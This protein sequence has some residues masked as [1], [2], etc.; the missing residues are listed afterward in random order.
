MI[1]PAT[2]KIHNLGGRLLDLCCALAVIEA[3]QRIGCGHIELVPDERHA[4]RRVEALEKHMSR[5]GHAIAIAVAQQH[6]AIWAWHPGAGES[7]SLGHQ[8]SSEPA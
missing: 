4:E 8:P 5:L 1:E 7:H 3:K 2:G 6:D